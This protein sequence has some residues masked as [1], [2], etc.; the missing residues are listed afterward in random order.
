MAKTFTK[1]PAEVVDYDIN[2]LDYF[3]DLTG[4]E[5]DTV[6]VTND[7]VTVPPLEIGPGVHPEYAKV[8][9]P[10][11]VVKIWTG[12]GLDGSKYKITAVI[13]TV[14]ARVE[15]VEFYLRV[16]ET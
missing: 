9:D 13:T 4:D 1:Q 6:V 10:A 5:V 12:A 8:G 16:K 15:E 14:L 11:H 2:M 7:T 3:D